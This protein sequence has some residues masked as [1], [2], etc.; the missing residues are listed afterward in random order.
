MGVADIFLQQITK[1]PSSIKKNTTFIF[2]RDSRY[3]KELIDAY[4]LFSVSFLNEEHR[5]A[6]QFFLSVPGTL[7]PC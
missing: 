1:L 7:F 5:T 3:T 6:M 2:V 4:D